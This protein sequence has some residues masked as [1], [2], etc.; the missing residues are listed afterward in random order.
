MRSEAGVSLP[1]V[2]EGGSSVASPS[3]STSSYRSTMPAYDAQRRGAHGGLNISGGKSGPSHQS[4]AAVSGGE[5]SEPS[6][7]AEEKRSKVR[8]GKGRKSKKGRQLESV[9]DESAESQ[10]VAR[11]SPILQVR[12]KDQF[13][14]ALPGLEAPEDDEVIMKL[15]YDA[16]QDITKSKTPTSSLETH[17]SLLLLLL[18]LLSRCD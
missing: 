3:E 15:S 4:S 9:I 18:L 1:G 5:R 17:L 10:S 14:R 7:Q 8:F 16:P 11:P 12:G 6:A 2:H 13:G